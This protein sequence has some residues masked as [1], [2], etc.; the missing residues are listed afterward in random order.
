MRRSFGLP[1]KRLW[2]SALKHSVSKERN[3]N[4]KYGLAVLAKH[5][6]IDENKKLVV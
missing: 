5:A 4:E 2:R 3:G 1:S 6:C